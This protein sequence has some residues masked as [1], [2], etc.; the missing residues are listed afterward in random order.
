[1]KKLIFTLLL[2][3][4][5]LGF[6]QSREVSELGGKLFNNKIRL[7]YILVHQPVNQVSYQLD[8]TMGFIGLNYNV[9][10]IDFYRK[11]KSWDIYCNMDVYYFFSNIRISVVIFHWSN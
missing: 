6:S 10:I 4:V 2:F 3:S 7:N 8:R 5:S 1:M 9:R 11:F